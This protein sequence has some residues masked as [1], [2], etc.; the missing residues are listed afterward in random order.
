M[1]LFGVASVRKHNIFKAHPYCKIYQ[2]FIPFY[3]QII[4]YS[5]DVPYFIYP[6]ISWGKF[7]MVPLSGYYE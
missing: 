2:Y 6:F 1:W 4:F 3:D 5:M 7:G